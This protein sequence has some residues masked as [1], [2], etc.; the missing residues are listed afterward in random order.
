M[1]RE[2]LLSRLTA[3]LRGGVD[4]VQVWRAWKGT[5]E[6]FEVVREIAEVTSDRGVPLL[7]NNDLAMAK[8]VDADGVHMDG[9]EHSPKEIRTRLGKTCIVG[10]TTGNDLTRVEWAE[11][12]GAD[13]IS[14]CSIFPSPSV[15]DCEI[16][17]LEVVRRARG[18][19]G[20][21]IFASG[22]ITLQNARQVLDAGA[23]GLAIVSAI[24]KAPDPQDV[25]SRFKSILVEARKSSP[26][27]TRQ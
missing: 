22:G 10:Y 5:D 21:P 18:L 1:E 14:F 11:R 13:Y 2:A 24:Q 8:R 4:L 26:S 6:S 25:A 20:M 19:V 12:E 9:F 15:T 17:P 23:D 7:I 3:A 27:F 16:V